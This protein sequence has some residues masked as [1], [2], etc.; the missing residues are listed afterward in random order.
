[1]TI[2]ARSTDPAPAGGWAT[3]RDGRPVLVRPARAADAPLVQAF[4]RGLS[5]LSRRRRF[6]G[7]VAELSPG[8]LDRLT[9]A[10]DPR[11][12]ALVALAPGSA[13]PA[14]V[15]MAQ[16][17]LESDGEAEFALAV[18]DDWHRQG[19]GSRLLAALLAHANEQGV[20]AL[21]GEV[22]VDNWPMLALLAAAGFELVDAGD[23]QL[24][25]ARK[26]LTPVRTRDLAR[27]LVAGWRTRDARV[28]QL[29]V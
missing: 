20:R 6:L 1:M 21:A 18:A 15:G 12:L 28:P 11:E 19:L 9:Q 22:L 26:P 5:P 27:R 14:I 8:Q 16:Y 2:P 25:R 10:H 23:P 17:A 7:P 3:L 4:V 13:T 24:C 29:A